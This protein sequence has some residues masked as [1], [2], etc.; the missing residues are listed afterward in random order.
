MYSS[1]V[2]CTARTLNTLASCTVNLPQLVKQ[3][4]ESESGD[5]SGAN[6]AD[7]DYRD[8]SEDNKPLSKRRVSTLGQG[9]YSRVG[10][11]L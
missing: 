7:S 3:E 5:E 10:S 6:G 4:P 9:Q 11:V 8:E 2:G 1:A